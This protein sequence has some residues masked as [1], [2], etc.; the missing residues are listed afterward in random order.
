MRGKAGPKT[1]GITTAKNDECH[2]ATAAVGRTVSQTL[3]AE[4]EAAST[5]GVL[6]R[7]VREERIG[8]WTG[9]FACISAFVYM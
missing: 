2:A 3:K 7:R 1:M 5:L 8:G 4:P 6:L 9:R